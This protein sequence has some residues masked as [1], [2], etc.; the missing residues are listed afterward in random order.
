MSFK[1]MILK[2]RCLIKILLEEYNH[3]LRFKSGCLN[4]GLTFD[5]SSPADSAWT[6]TVDGAPSRKYRLK[7]TNDGLSLVTKGMMVSFK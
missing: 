7:A 4:L 2:I 3:L 1:I 6:L 5:G